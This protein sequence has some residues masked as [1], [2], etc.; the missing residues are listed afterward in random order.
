[1]SNVV[2]SRMFVV[3]VRLSG[4]YCLYCTHALVSAALMQLIVDA[5]RA[6]LSFLFLFSLYFLWPIGL[7]LLPTIPDTLLC[8]VLLFRCF[9]KLDAQDDDDDAQDKETGDLEIATLPG[10]G[11]EGL[12]LRSSGTRM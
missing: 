12:S 3:A 8:F 6:Q 5:S 4:L 11:A 2:Y 1:M 7:L 10:K 9:L